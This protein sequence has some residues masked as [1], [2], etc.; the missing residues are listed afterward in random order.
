MMNGLFKNN[1]WV[2]LAGDD[3]SVDFKATTSGSENAFTGLVKINEL[4]LARVQ[5]VQGKELNGETDNVLE[6]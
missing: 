3:V 2:I 5:I 1:L 4:P 6:S